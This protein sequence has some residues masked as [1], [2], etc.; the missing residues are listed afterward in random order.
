MRKSWT[1]NT[2]D[3]KI[4][5][6][7][8]RTIVLPTALYVIETWRQ[9]GAIAR[10]LN[11]FHQRCLRKIMKISYLNHVTNEE[12]LKHAQSPQ[13]QD[14]VTERRLKMAGQVLP[15]PDQRPP[16]ITFRWR[17]NTRKRKE[18]KPRSTW[19]RTFQEDLKRLG[20]SWDTIEDEAQDRSQW[21]MLSARCPNMPQKD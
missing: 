17:P 15:L 14:I 2:I 12:V 11:T 3:L 18:V 4:K 6:Q 10:K 7:L 13:I 16:K 9:T 8:Y 21:R 1:S 20:K 19:R 5:P